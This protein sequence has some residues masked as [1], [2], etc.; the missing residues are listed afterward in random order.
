MSHPLVRHVLPRIV[1]AALI[2]VGCV[3]AAV[4]LCAG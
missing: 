4:A 1:L 2:T 3:G